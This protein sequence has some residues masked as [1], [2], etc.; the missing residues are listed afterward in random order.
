MPSKPQ[1]RK[2]CG[3]GLIG[4]CRKEEISDASHWWITRKAFA[5]VSIRVYK[6]TAKP[7]IPMAVSK[8]KLEPPISFIKSISFRLIHLLP[9]KETC[10]RHSH[11]LT[12]P[13]LRVLLIQ[14]PFHTSLCFIWGSSLPCGLLFHS[15]STLQTWELASVGQGSLC[16]WFQVSSGGQRVLM[17]D[18]S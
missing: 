18:A 17:T 11:F 13:F 16:T 15:H 7:C 10:P 9:R 8:R 5:L 12:P 14:G 1:I 2:V 3:S 4:H 6:L